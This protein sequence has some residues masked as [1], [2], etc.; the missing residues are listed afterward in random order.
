M[1]LSIYEIFFNE[2][3]I[4]FMLIVLSQIKI[5]MNIF[6]VEKKKESVQLAMLFLIGNCLWHA[7]FINKAFS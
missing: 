4:E 3:Q 2:Y 1:F 6:L 5:Q 7:V